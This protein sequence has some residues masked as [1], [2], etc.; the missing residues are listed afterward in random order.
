MNKLILQ[1]RGLSVT[2]LGSVIYLQGIESLPA[3]SNYNSYRK[4][5]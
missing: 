4:K 5:K 2:L 3:Q 1:S